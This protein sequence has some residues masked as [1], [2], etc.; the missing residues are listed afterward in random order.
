MVVVHQ[1]RHT[2]F[3]PGSFFRLP[4][5]LNAHCIQYMC[6]YS[7][8]RFFINKKQKHELASVMDSAHLTSSGDRQEQQRRLGPKQG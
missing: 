2:S 1:R 5:G 3:A 4:L 8:V 7:L 6:L